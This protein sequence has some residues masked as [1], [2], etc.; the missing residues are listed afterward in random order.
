MQDGDQNT[1]G[2]KR[3][4]Q[5]TG[6]P[7]DSLACGKT[8]MERLRQSCDEKWVNVGKKP[9]RVTLIRVSDAVR[10]LKKNNSVEMRRMC[11]R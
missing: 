11:N 9:E 3:P 1:N 2:R 5:K 7:R 4:K 10:A 8:L 6:E